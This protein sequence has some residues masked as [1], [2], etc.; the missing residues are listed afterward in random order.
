MR[1]DAIDGSRARFLANWFA[2]HSLMVAVKP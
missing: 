2:P 1:I